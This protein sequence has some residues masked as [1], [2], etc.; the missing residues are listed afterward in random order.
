MFSGAAE[1]ICRWETLKIFDIYQGTKQNTT[2]QP[3]ESHQP[4]KIV[5][6]LLARLILSLPREAVRDAKDLYPVLTSE[7][8]ALQQSAYEILHL[9]I[10]TKQEQISL[11]AALS[12][13]FTPKL[14]EELLSLILTTPS[15]DST[16][17]AS[18][19]STMPATLRGYLLSWILVFDH[20]TNASY[21]IQASYV[22]CVKE[23]IY[24]TSLLN[25]ISNSLVNSRLKPVD[26]SKFEIESYLP[27]SAET[28]EK[29]VQWI[30][31]H[32]YYLSLKRLPSLSRSWWR[33]DISRQTLIA[34]ESW[35][36]KYVSHP[37]PGI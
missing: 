16:A 14:P 12:K 17:D 35:T 4:R 8:S 28:T 18:F 13:E 1:G 10:P 3:D 19:Q 20:W 32:L 23:G 2:D 21:K 36:E 7:S 34:V 27:G 25:L 24:L 15:L 29:D 26:A 9:S 11:D 5:N 6:Q 30:L 22:E 31:I 37:L 33:D